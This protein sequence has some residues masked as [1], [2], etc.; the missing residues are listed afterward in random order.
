VSV[1]E[2]GFVFVNEYCATEAPGVWAIGDIVRGPMLA[3]KGS[4]EGVMVAERI[5]GKA[6]QLNYE[7]VPSI[8]YTHPEVAAVGKTEQELRLEGAQIKVG[9]FPFAAIG[10][11]QAS[12]ETDGLVKIIADADSDQILGAHVVGPSAADLVQQI[13]IA[14]EMAASTEDL[15]LMV[16]GHPTMSEAVHEAALAVDSRAIHMVNRP[17][18]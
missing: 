13:V 11:A 16:F 18:R 14:M 2:R 15:Q 1:D 7:V 9:T 8:I 5:H 4:E 17:K 3:H 10:R 6:A 12:G